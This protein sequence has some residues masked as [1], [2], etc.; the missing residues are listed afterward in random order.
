MKIKKVIVKPI[1]NNQ[2][3]SYIE[4]MFSLIIM[5][6]VFVLMTQ[7]FYNINNINQ[8]TFDINVLVYETAIT[9]IELDLK[10]VDQSNLIIGENYLQYTIDSQLYKYKINGTRFTLIIGSNDKFIYY[11]NDVKSVSFEQVNNFINIEFID[12]NNQNYETKIILSP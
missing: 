9:R 8:K 10:E 12:I 7:I 4:L 3:N 5:I 1:L 11:I 6:N 2:G